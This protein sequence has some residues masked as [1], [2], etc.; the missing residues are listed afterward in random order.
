MD[1]RNDT[2]RQDQERTLT[3]DNKSGASFSEE[4]RGNV[5]QVRV[6]DEER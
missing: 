4:Y 5:E 2:P 6:R 1:V 3:R